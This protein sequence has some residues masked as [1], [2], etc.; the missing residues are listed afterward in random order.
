MTMW[1]EP[2]N[3]YNPSLPPDGSV[4]EAEGTVADYP[5]AK[6]G[7]GLEV[8][9]GVGDGEGEGLVAEDVVGVAA[10]DGVAVE[11]GGFSQRFSRPR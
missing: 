1:A 7:H 9:E 2:P 3:P 5:G 6:E 8:G 10:V 4:G 11:V